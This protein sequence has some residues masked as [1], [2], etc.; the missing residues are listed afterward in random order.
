MN[1]RIQ[2]VRD[3]LIRHGHSGSI[4]GL[5][6]RALTAAAATVQQL[7]CAVGAIAN[8]LIFSVNDSPMLVLTSGA[9]RVDAR[10]VANLLDVGRARICRA[11]PEFVLEVTCQEIGGGAP[12]GT[13]SRSGPSSTRTSTPAPRYRPEPACTTRCSARRSTN[14]SS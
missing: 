2:L 8:S 3:T 1:T 10:K 5:P 6:E 4:T 11:T 13:P 9:H 7:G 12:I 14:C